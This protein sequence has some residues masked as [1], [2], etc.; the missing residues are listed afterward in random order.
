MGS[1]AV[2]VVCRDEGAA[3]RTFGVIDEGF[4]ACFTRTG[5]RFFEDDAL[6]RELLTRTRDAADEVRLFDRLC[7]E[8]LLLDCELMPWSVKAQ[9]LLRE[10]YAAV[11]AAARVGLAERNGTPRCC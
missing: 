9:E 8:W 6:E 4:G 11:G 10:Q 7:T 2:V 3:R 1:R 5:R